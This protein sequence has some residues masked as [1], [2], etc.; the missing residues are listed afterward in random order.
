MSVINQMLKD[1]DQRQTEQPSSTKQAMLVSQARKLPMSL[2]WLVG[3]LVIMNISGWFIWKIYQENQQLKQNVTMVTQQVAEQS[4]NAIDRQ[5]INTMQLAKQQQVAAEHEQP[6][7][8]PLSTAIKPTPE[9]AQTTTLEQPEEMRA[10]AN[11]TIAKIAID[12]DTQTK[13]N[14]PSLS[15]TRKQTSPAQLAQQKMDKAELAI[16]DHEIKLAEQLLADVLLLVPEHK[17]ARR[18]LAALWFGRQD[19]QSAINTLSQGITLAPTD[20][21]FRLMQARIYLKQGALESAYQTLLPVTV[22]GEVELLTLFAGLAQQLKYFTEAGMA[23]RQLSHTQPEQGKWW[24]GIAISDDSQGAFD[25]AKTSYQLALT[26][27]NLTQD[28]R[29]FATQRLQ[30]LGE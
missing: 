4:N 29:Q 30:Q 26:K 2:V 16:A 22:N 3:V 17:A 10:I 6:R 24:L 23:Y 28:A 14:K 1:L 18:Q 9:P 20:A 19:Y 11:A 12:T 7:T 21:E 5:P 15:I 27:Q 8:L 25:Q 13:L